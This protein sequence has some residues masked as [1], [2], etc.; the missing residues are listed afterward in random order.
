M[1]ALLE[2][3]R[4]VEGMVLS[5]LGCEEIPGWAGGSFLAVWLVDAKTAPPG[6]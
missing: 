6:G 2:P 4:T 5:L 1:E 3:G